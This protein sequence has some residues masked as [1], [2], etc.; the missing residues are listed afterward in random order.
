M[1]EEEKI[2]IGVVA[3][4]E[5]GGVGPRT[6]QL[7][8][9]HF[10]TPQGVFDSPAGA[11]AELPRMSDER[12]EQIRIA[13][14]H[15]DLIRRRLAE[16]HDRGIEVV[17]VFDLGYP[18][19][20]MEIGDTPPL[21][22]WKGNFELL[23]RRCVAIVGSHEATSEGISEA[24]RYGKLIAQAGAVVV[25][26]LAKGIDGA[27]HLGALQSEGRTIAVLG[28]GFDM[29]FP[30]ENLPLS[31]SISQNGLLLSEYAPETEVTVGRLIARNRLI[32]GLSKSVIVVE[33]T[34]DSG[35]TASAIEETIKQGKALSSRPRGMRSSPKGW[36]TSASR[37]SPITRRL[38]RAT[39][40]H[41]RRWP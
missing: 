20:L 40:R 12:E 4:R 10:G 3:L 5:Y 35:G 14:D 33:V 22:Y 9:T 29:M 28:C 17:T 21:L 41:G 7:L 34:P 1:N 31:E 30:A 19:S 38:R 36:I 32:V 23:Q 16:Y 6:F 13:V 26:G 8:M 39:P 11:I 2:K 24:V 37:R 27:A 18:E 15:F 25:S